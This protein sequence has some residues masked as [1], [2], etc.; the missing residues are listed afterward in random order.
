VDVDRRRRNLVGRLLSVRHVSVGSAADEVDFFA[1][2]TQLATWVDWLKLVLGVLLLLVALREWRARPHEGDEP[3]TPKWMAALD[4]F[5]PAKADGAGVLL[6]AVNPKNLL[7]IV[8]GAAA[9][10]CS[11]TRSPGFSG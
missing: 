5:T 8:G 4:G 1:A 7:L 9:E 10:S 11:A 2:Q 6:S 3:A